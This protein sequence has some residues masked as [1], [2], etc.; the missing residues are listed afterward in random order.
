[1]IIISN[2]DVMNRCYTLLLLT[3]R[4]DSFYYYYINTYCDLIIILRIVNYIIIKWTKLVRQWYY[5]FIT[6]FGK[7][8][9]LLYTYE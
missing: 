4:I 6:K 5:C 8:V 1:M 9:I 3:T 2:D 7:T